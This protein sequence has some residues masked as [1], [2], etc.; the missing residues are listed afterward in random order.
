MEWEYRGQTVDEMRSHVKTFRTVFKNVVLVFGAA[1]DT[2]GVMMLGSD[3]PIAITH[4]G[5]ESVLSRP[6][7]VE[8]LSGAPDSPPG[9]TTAAAWEQKIV[10][11]IWLTGGDVDKFAASGTLITDDR[12]YTE[13]DLLRSRFGPKSPQALRANLLAAM[14]ASAP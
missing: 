1:A 7:V 12:P 6:G 10:S 9:V 11:N 3:D 8:D 14:P 4:A 2:Y 13:Y 5:M